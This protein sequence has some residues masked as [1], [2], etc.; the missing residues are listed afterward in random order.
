MAER[1]GSFNIHFHAAPGGNAAK[2]L[3]YPATVVIPTYA[4]PTMVTDLWAMGV[5]TCIQ[6]STN[7]AEG[8]EYI[9]KILLP[10]DPSGVFLSPFDRSDI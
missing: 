6:H 5:T 3:R 8:Q 1:R 4:K 10:H 2:L 7:I 9:Q